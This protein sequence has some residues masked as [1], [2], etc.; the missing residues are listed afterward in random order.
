MDGRR[1][2]PH[3]RWTRR[4]SLLSSG[5]ITLAALVI[6]SAACSGSDDG[7]AFDGAGVDDATDAAV[8][9]DATEDAGPPTEDGVA[10]APDVV[11]DAPEPGPYCG[12]PAPPLFGDAP[13]QLPHAVPDPQYFDA[14]L[15]QQYCHWNA[16]CG[17]S[18]TT[19]DCALDCEILLETGRIANA[20][21][22]VVGCQP[23]VCLV[24]EVIP[25]PP[26]CVELCSSSATCTDVMA[27][28]LPPEPYACEIMCAGTVAVIPSFADALDCMAPSVA[29]CD[30]GTAVSCL[31]DGAVFCP[32]LCG[33]VGGCQGAPFSK[34]WE[35]RE[36]CIADCSGWTPEKA[37]MAANCFLV[38]QCQA[39]AECFATPVTEL[40]TAWAQAMHDACEDEAW[41]PTIDLAA[42]ACQSLV[43]SYGLSAHPDPAGCFANFPRCPQ[44][45][46]P[47]APCVLDAP[48]DC[49]GLCDAFC[50]CELMSRLGCEAFCVEQFVAGGFQQAHHTLGCVEE[51]AC[52]KTDVT[53]CMIANNAQPWGCE[54]YCQTV[55]DC[56]G[57]QGD[58]P[59]VCYAACQGAHTQGDA[60][61]FAEIVCVG[62]DGGCDDITAC[63]ATSPPT[64]SAVCAAAC[65]A[66]SQLCH[67][68]AIGFD[69]GETACEVVCA[70]LLVAH[71]HEDDAATAACVASQLDHDC[72]L[73]GEIDCFAD[74]SGG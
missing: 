69:N 42:A 12:P 19:G 11:P 27:L 56:P 10:A 1:L 18:T 49:D 68:I 6:L 4:P 21:C 43:S 63:K 71:G 73:I 46:L 53:S 3:A 45:G 47:Q 31:A 58:S 5:S 24:D 61:W 72:L 16:H 60:S 74:G 44:P 37:Y 15:C 48:E 20:A 57:Y 52:Q 70:Q 8:T 33:E 23:D 41:P 25:V 64:K 29:V 22:Y 17:D 32:H 54:A 7:G 40:C 51:A 38:D 50:E 36:A 28:G 30:L 65:E 13:L 9:Q 59:G 67:H 66:D 34:V 39:D 55:A 2:S 62:A 26:A 35:S 14:S